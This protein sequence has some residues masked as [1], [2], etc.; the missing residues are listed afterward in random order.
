MKSINEQPDLH[1]VRPS[2]AYKDE[3]LEFYQEWKL[4]GE[5]M[6]PWVIEK[7]PADFE[8]MLNWLKRK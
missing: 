8:E 1:L 3:Y 4:S 6:V 7:D 5:D 2:L